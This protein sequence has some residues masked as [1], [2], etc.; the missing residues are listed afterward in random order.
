MTFAPPFM[1]YFSLSLNRKKGVVMG[2]LR[3]KLNIFMLQ[4]PIYYTLE[5]EIFFL[6]LVLTRLIEGGEYKISFCHHRGFRASPQTYREQG[7]II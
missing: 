5:K 4:L 1:N 2:A 7:S 6:F 3:K